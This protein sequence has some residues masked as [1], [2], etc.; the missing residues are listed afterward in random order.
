MHLRM[1]DDQAIDWTLLRAFVA[2]METGSLT[3]AARQLALTQPTLGRQVRALEARIGETLF[4]R[5]PG[6]LRPTARATELFERARAVEQAVAGLSASLLSPA[7]P[8]L[9][10]C[11]RIT[12]SRLFACELLPDMLAPLL[13]AHPGLRIELVADDG[14]ADLIRREADVA[15]RLARP[16]QPDVI[17]RQVGEVGLGLHASRD[18]LA[19]H[20]WPDA[21]AGLAGHRVIGPADAAATLARA[22]ALGIALDESQLRLRCDDHL[23]QLGALRAGLG[24]G[25]CHDWFA[26]RSPGLARL[27][28]LAVPPLPLWLAA[29]DDLPRS[30]RIRV[31][32]DHLAA[33]LAAM[34]GAVS[35]PL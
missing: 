33:R 17:A 26:A 32:F 23:A 11:V 19:R 9:D 20:G 3:R 16:T 5:L 10:G 8:A 27:D 6:G 31:V 35:P 34:F 4:D 7:S 2:V 22:A 14:L 13:D 28:G 30:R 15:V 25:L 24:I 29:H 21:R 18:Y 12:A 1:P